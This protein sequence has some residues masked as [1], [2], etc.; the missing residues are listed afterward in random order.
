[1]RKPR[2]SLPCRSNWSV[3]D[4]QQVVLS[5]CLFS[6]M[7]HTC[8]AG[9]FLENVHRYVCVNVVSKAALE[10]LT[11]LC[12]CVCV[13]LAE[14]HCLSSPCKNGG[15]CTRKI[16]TFV[17]QCTSGFHGSTCDKGKACWHRHNCFV[18]DTMH[19]YDLTSL[20]DFFV[21]R[22]TSNGCRY[23]NGGCEHFCKEFPNRTHT[24]FCATG[25][26]LDQDN[27]TC[28]PQGQSSFLTLL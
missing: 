28:S 20:Y 6:L 12:V 21:A 2:R 26:R 4:R 9:G 16:N 18:T 27:S 13:F 5:N 8:F 22:L 11:D 15:T 19:V 10:K 3:Y 1:M 14:D 25:Y 17:C 23:R 24:C 7:C